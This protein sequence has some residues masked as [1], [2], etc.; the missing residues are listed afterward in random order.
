[1]TWPPKMMFWVV[2]TFWHIFVRGLAA[3]PACHPPPP[4]PLGVTAITDHPRV[5]EVWPGCGLQSGIAPVIIL[6]S[7]QSGLWRVRGWRIHRQAWSL[8]LS[9]WIVGTALI[10][11]CPET[12]HLYGAVTHHTRFSLRG[13]GSFNLDLISLPQLVSKWVLVLSHLAYDMPR[14]S[15][16]LLRLLYGDIGFV[17]PAC[18]WW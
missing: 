6:I 5:V 18:L 12:G 17:Y 8:V 14:V 1:M 15:R 11:E 7:F 3:A 13:P 16:P 4:L 9:K 10:W 2:R